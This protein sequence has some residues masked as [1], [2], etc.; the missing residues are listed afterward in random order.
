MQRIDTADGLFHEAQP[1]NDIPATR[2]TDKW[3]NSVQE[4]LISVL[5][6]ANLTPDEKDNTQQR[7]AILTY[8]QN[9]IPPI[10]AELL[11]HQKTP[12]PLGVSLEKDLEFCLFHGVCERF[13]GTH[14]STQ[15]VFEFVCYKKHPSEGP[16]W[17]SSFK[18]FSPD[19]K[20]L[21][22]QLSVTADGEIQ[23]TSEPQ[24]EPHQGR[25]YLSYTKR[26]RA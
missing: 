19:Q 6:L 13:A 8:F 9:G 20:G 14:P 17:L 16:I 24:E 12:R 25:L 23:Y 15:E 10:K 21:S 18:P 11:N 26:E 1:E 3:L 4:E 5:K 2:I 22:F 7:T